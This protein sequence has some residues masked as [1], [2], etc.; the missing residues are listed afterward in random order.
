MADRIKI[1]KQLYITPDQERALKERA[2]KEG[3]AEAEI[4]R[5][6]LD[7]H[8]RHESGPVLSG[9][10]RKAVEELIAM[11]EEVA[12]HHRF[13]KGYKF[14]RDELYADREERLVKKRD[15]N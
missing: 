8:L 4:V 14:D 1:R 3:V 5:E 9:K 12:L 11:N 10:R 7:R 6:A 13:P 15:S 2:R